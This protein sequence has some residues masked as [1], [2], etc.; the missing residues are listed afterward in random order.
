MTAPV[1]APTAAAARRVTFDMARLVGDEWTRV[2]EGFEFGSRGRK[3]KSPAYLIES[4]IWRGENKSQRHLTWRSLS[5]RLGTLL[6]RFFGWPTFLCNLQVCLP[7]EVDVY[8]RLT[9][10]KYLGGLCQRINPP[11]ITTQLCALIIHHYSSPLL[12]T[13]STPFDPENTPPVRSKPFKN[14]PFFT[15]NGLQKRH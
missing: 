10:K 15:S 14:V 2:G 3:G 5:V 8:V 6:I 1:T 4:Q 11:R 7:L 13:P 12:V 9:R